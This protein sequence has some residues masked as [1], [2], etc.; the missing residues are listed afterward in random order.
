MVSK[1]RIRQG[2]SDVWDA[3]KHQITLDLLSLITKATDFSR[4]LYHIA[5]QDK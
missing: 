3:G 1:T 4:N 2:V 5:K